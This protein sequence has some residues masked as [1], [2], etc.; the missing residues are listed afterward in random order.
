MYRRPLPFLFSEPHTSAMT[1]DLTVRIPAGIV[2]AHEI[3][4]VYDEHLQ[5]LGYFGWNWDAFDECM[6]TL[7]WLDTELVKNVYIY[8]S[9][10]PFSNDDEALDIYRYTPR[11]C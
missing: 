2:D 3:F 6:R 11:C 7:E 10:V 4:K 9:G 1:D 8:H 5:W